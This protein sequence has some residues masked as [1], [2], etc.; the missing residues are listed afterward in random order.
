MESHAA[1]TR[2][3]AAFDDPDFAWELKHD[4]YRAVAYIEDG[5]WLQQ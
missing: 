5:G 4:G 1:P 3:R 2:I